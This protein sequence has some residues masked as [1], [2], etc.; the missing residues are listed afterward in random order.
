MVTKI[1]LLF[2]GTVLLVGCNSSN[3]PSK[4]EALIACYEWTFDKKVVTYKE[5]RVGWEAETKGKSRSCKDESE[6]NQVLGFMNQ[7]MDNGDW[8]EDKNEG[9]F[10]VVKRFRY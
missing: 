2:L 8:I 1:L 4:T 7:V 9:K 5:P 10:K 6:T 3:Y